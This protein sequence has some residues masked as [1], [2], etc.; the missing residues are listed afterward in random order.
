MFVAMGDYRK[1]EVWKLAVSVSDR[2]DAL[3]VR[4]GHR[5]RTGLGDQ[6]VRAAESIHLN[7]AEGCGLNSDSQLAR[8]IRIALGSANELED[9]LGK[10]DRRRLLQPED[11]TL[12]LDATILRRKLG[13]FLR[14]V[15]ATRG[16]R[17]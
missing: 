1:L 4:L 8:H 3:V 7:I 16:A 17:R 6:L 13:A 15:V 14:R 12:V 9:E 2:V 10:L 5:D 11:E